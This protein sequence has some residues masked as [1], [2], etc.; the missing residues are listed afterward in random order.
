MPP[1]KRQDKRVTAIRIDLRE[2]EVQDLTLPPTV[3]DKRILMTENHQ[4]QVEAEVEEIPEKCQVKAEAEVRTET[5]PVKAEVEERPEKCQ[6]KVEAEERLEKCH[7]KIEAEER[8]ETNLVKAEVEVRA[9]TSQVQVEEEERTEIYQVQAEVEDQVDINR[10][11][12][13]HLD[14]MTTSHPKETTIQVP[15][16]KVVKVMS[17]STLEDSVTK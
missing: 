5:F 17:M 4:V 1:D 15:R 6:V 16:E 10:R 14:T 11:I 2:A 3:G 13:N 12:L 7:M 9:E 8:T